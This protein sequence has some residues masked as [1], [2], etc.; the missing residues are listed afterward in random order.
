MRKLKLD[1]ESLAVD[2]FRTSRE[3]TE[4]GTAFAHGYAPG[5]TAELSRAGQ[6]GPDGG[7]IQIWP[8][9][10]PP[11]ETGYPDATCYGTCY[12]SCGCSI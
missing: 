10:P 8:K 5:D 12:F 9:Q 7:V 11:M 4:R 6:C 3:M 2:S 1:V